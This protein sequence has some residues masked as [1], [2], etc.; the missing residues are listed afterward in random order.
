MRHTLSDKKTSAAPDSSGSG[1]FVHVRSVT[2]AE[3]VLNSHLVRLQQLE[4]KVRH[5]EKLED[6]MDTSL[7]KRLLFAFDG[8]P[9][10]RVVARPQ[11]RPWR[12][13]WTS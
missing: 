10:F 4:A 3:A 11:W 6:V 2:D 7:P 5:L 8:W 12:R 1:V 9:L 13:W